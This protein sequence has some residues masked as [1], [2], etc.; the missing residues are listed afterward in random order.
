M[1]IVVVGGAGLIGSKLVRK[2][3]AWGHE[4]RSA[5]RSSG[6]DTLTGK[7][8][9][10]ALAGTQAVVDVTNP[11]SFDE[12][13]VSGFFETSE[14]N[15][16]AAAATA[17]P[18]VHVVALSIVG[19]DRLPD[20]FHLRAK[21]K[22]EQL[23]E[24]SGLPYTIVRCTQ[25]FEFLGAIA[26][27]GTVEGSVR[28][29]PAFV[30]PIASDDVVNAMAHTVGRSPVNGVVEIAGPEHLPLHEVVSQY[31]KAM[32]DPRQI[33]PDADARYFGAQLNDHSLIPGVHSWLG[34]LSIGEWLA[35][36]RCR[37]A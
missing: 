18:T 12:N 7:G 13:V 23:I 20:N 1:K 37:I 24:A 31:L 21:R 22:Q 16:M 27:A 5:S 35:R 8:L 14:R 36:S 17:G 26:D 28:L 10:E 4:V 9:D 29:S 3:R 15:L 32:N 33:V 19:A 30:Q 2:L 25:F 6:V 11:P 34:S